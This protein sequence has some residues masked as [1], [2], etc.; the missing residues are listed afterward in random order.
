MAL[1]AKDQSLSESRRN[2][3]GRDGVMRGPVATGSFHPRSPSARDRGTHGVVWR[4]SRDRGTRPLPGYFRH[5]NTVNLEGLGIWAPTPLG[6]CEVWAP[7]LFGW[8]RVGRASSERED[9]V[10]CKVAQGHAACAAGK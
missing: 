10:C 9:V 1:E 8:Q 3:T 6:K 2:D 4:R 7:G 5:I